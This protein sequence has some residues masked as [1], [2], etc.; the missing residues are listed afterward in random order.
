MKQRVNRACHLVVARF[1]SHELDVEDQTSI[2]GN[3]RRIA[4]LTIGQ[5][6]RDLQATLLTDAHAQETLIPALDNGA[7]SESESEWSAALETSIELS[8]VF[9]FALLRHTIRKIGDVN[10]LQPN[11]NN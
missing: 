8:T 1:K 3:G 11:L 9:E 10:R 5:V 6:R 4:A 7:R 2:G